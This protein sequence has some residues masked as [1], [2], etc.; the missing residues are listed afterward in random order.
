MKFSQQQ[1]KPLESVNASMLNFM[2]H[3]SWKGNIRELENLV[4]R[5]VTIANTEA[6]V[7]DMILLPQEFSKEIDQLKYKMSINEQ[8]LSLPDRIHSY[9]KDLI[10]KALIE[11]NWN[12]SQAARA[13]KISE[14]T[15]RQ[16]MKKLNLSKPA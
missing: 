11:N 8:D 1:R 16:K 4:E 5:L 2:I 13:L 15:I 6:T 7:L 12:Q 9:E 10:N 3:R 14:G